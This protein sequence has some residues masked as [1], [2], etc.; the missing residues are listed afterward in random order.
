[1][2]VR[3]PF[4][5]SDLFFGRRQGLGGDPV[6]PD[7]AVPADDDVGTLTFEGNQGGPKEGGLNIGQHE[8]LYM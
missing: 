7:H 6:P 3:S 4:E 8:S 1:M 2:I 5:S